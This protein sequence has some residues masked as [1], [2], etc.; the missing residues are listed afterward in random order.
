MTFKYYSAI[1]SLNHHVVCNVSVS[2][3]ANKDRNQL[4][5]WIDSDLVDE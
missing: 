3:K 1:R 2:C 5:A 4:G